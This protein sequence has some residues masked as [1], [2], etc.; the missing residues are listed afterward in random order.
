MASMSRTQPGTLPPPPNL[1]HARPQPLHFSAIP[2]SA[3][4]RPR[5]DAPRLMPASSPVRQHRVRS[6]E[7]GGSRNH[8]KGRSERTTHHRPPASKLQ[9]TPAAT[10]PRV[11]DG[12]DRRPEAA[13]SSKRAKKPVRGPRVR[14]GALYCVDNASKRV[15][16]AHNDAEPLP[17][18]SITKLLTAMVV[19]DTMDLD[20]VL[21]AP[22]D[23]RL[24]PE[25]R[26]GLRPG[27][28]LTVR[29]LL[30]GML[31][32]S[33]NDCAEVLARAYPKGGRS[34]FILTMNRKAA[35]LG[36]RTAI[37]YTPSGLDLKVA[38]GR[39]KGRTLK[40]RKP[41]KA[42][43][44]DVAKIA[45]FAFENYPLIRKIS[46]TKTHMIKTRNKKARRYAL[47]SNDKLLFRR[48]PVAGA[49]TGFTNLAGR[50]IVA[51]FKDKKD[52]YTV[53]VLNT[54]HHFKAAER[55]Y[56]WAKK[57]F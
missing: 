18:A 49:K 6:G 34:G 47:R 54:R 51:Q 21:K 16:F 17:I 24:V 4:G 40:A 8:S 29:D 37:L 14:A 33:G 13:R 20:A 22:S 32:V 27:D 9:D 46:S 1:V 55:V 11:T 52:D 48:V 39:I 44:A 12:R 53:V 5:T 57:A 3:V 23:I 2:I 10:R 25:K 45:Q 56:H 50:C 7:S 36:A 19:I 30:H 15:L 43:A 26:L 41:N 31:I 38:L 35:Q 28:R 42:S